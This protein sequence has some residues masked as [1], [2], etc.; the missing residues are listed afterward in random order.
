MAV[1]VAVYQNLL[2]LDLGDVCH[3]GFRIEDLG[4]E[5]SAGQDPLPIQV[6]AGER[7]SVVTTYD[8][9]WIHTGY[10]FDNEISEHR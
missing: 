6:D 9:I 1:N 4:V 10:H 7:A 2:V 5:L 8:T 3:Q